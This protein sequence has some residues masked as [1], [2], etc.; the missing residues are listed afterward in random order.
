[1]GIALA[2]SCTANAQNKTFAAH[3]TVKAV[4]TSAS[5]DDNGTV[6]TKSETESKYS[7]D[8]ELTY[9]P[10]INAPTKARL[11]FCSDNNAT[12]NFITG[13]NA[14]I[15]Y[16]S[17]VNKGANQISAVDFSYRS[18][19]WERC[20]NALKEI[21][22]S[23]GGGRIYDYMVTSSIGFI[24]YTPVTD[25]PEPVPL[26]KPKTNDDF[27]LIPLVK[28]DYGLRLYIN[29][30]GITPNI[31]AKAPKM[32]EQY[33]DC[34]IDQWMNNDPSKFGLSIP[35]HA[36]LSSHK[37]SSNTP[38]NYYFSRYTPIT[39]AQVQ[40]LI[41]TGKANW[42]LKFYSY[43]KDLGTDNKPLNETETKIWVTLSIR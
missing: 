12:C 26:V 18:S 28:G 17:E 23:E 40:S 4:T 1:L 3:L 34:T 14:F 36:E 41:K 15:P 33:R 24:K 38:E 42:E 8:Q 9:F 25:E 10:G 39:D 2:F 20:E 27:K 6:T 5:F 11:E 13:N 37:R 43:S 35:D 16:P 31:N 19:G 22:K 32:K 30:G 29:I 7:V 21:H